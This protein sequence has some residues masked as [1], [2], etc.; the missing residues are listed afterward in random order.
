MYFCFF[1]AEDG[2][3][4][5][6][7]TGVQTCALPISLSYDR[8]E[9]VVVADNCTD[10]TVAI[11]RAA[12]V[13]VWERSDPSRRGKG[14]ALAWAIDRVRSERPDAGAVVVVDAD[15]TAS[16]NMLTEMARRLRTGDDAVQ[17]R[18][19]VANPE[20][21]AASAAR[22]AAFALVNVVRPRGR[23]ALGLSAGLLGSGMAFSTERLDRVPWT[24]HGLT[25]D[26]E[27]HLRL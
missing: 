3:R 6:G 10:A 15:C 18:Y 25:E 20:A 21:S 23:S 8:Y 26:A 22:Y 13:T 11:A 27:Q 7:V 17:V 5:I 19:T 2:I 9:V 4:D 16:P 1:Q 14:W 24:S 12:G